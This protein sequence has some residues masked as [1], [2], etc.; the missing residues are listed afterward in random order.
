MNTINRFFKGPDLIRFYNQISYLVLV[1]L[2]VG[3]LVSCKPSA[4]QSAPVTAPL[5]LPVRFVNKSGATT[6]VEYPASVQGAVDIDVRPQI[7]GYIQSVLVNEGA[8]VAAGQTLFT[9]N[10]QPFIEALNNAKAG[11]HAAEA[12]MLNTQLEID[13]LTPLVE[14]KVV[15]EIQLKTAKAAYKVAEANAEQARAAVEAAKINLGY[16]RITSTVSGYIGRIPKKQG[17]LVSP[18]DQAALTQLSDIHEVHV[19]FAMAEN[20]FNT[21]NI[22]YAGRTPAERI[23]NLPPVELVL[24]N[25]TVY[26]HKGKIDMIDGQF[27]KS[28]GAITFRATFPNAAGNLRSGNTGKLRLGLIHENTIS[29][30]QSAT[31]EMQD[32]IFVFAVNKEN[33]VNKTSINVIGKSGTNYLI[34][35]G[36]KSGDQIVLSG[37]DRLQEGQ[38]IQPQKAPE[39]AAQINTRN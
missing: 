4:N 15:S 14:N 9:I 24:P 29:V 7:S 23:K 10:A 26:A 33:I 30:P 16:T 6:F 2:T 3:T 35:N 13:K 37:L 19:Y 27:D 12:A 28:T 1:L 36:L 11:L 31:F 8:Y 5:A 32:K 22:S 38:V 25:N 34:N 39:M 21:F 17:S 18:N 20:D